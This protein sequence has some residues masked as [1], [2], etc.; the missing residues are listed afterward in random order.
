MRLHRPAF[1]LAALACAIAPTLKG[2]TATG[3]AALAPI[4]GVWQSDTTNGNSALS[5]CVWTP[6]GGAVLCE[7]TITTPGGMRHAENLFTWDSTTSHYFLYVAQAPGDTLSPVP[8]AITGKVWTYGGLTAAPNGKWW[9]T[10]N[11]FST[12]GSY[13]WRLESSDDG[14]RWTRVMGGTSRRV[15]RR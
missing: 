2:Q 3:R 9:R 10:I 14:S 5:D 15:R 8:L 1:T 11:D 4:V 6:Q 13:T 12:A 7:Q